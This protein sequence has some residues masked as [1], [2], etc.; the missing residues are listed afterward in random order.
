MR[1]TGTW[2]SLRL[3]CMTFSFANF[4]SY[5]SVVIVVFCDNVITLCFDNDKLLCKPLARLIRNSFSLNVVCCCSFCVRT[6][7]NS[8]FAVHADMDIDDDSRISSERISIL[9]LQNL[10]LQMNHIDLIDMNF[11]FPQQENNHTLPALLKFEQQKNTIR[12]WHFVQKHTKRVYCLH[13]I[14]FTAENFIRMCQQLFD[15]MNHTHH[16]AG[17]PVGINKRNDDRTTHAFLCVAKINS[18]FNLMSS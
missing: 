5:F 13:P 7:Y 6:S 14:Q 4:A 8:C 2:D 3:L 12:K 16:S 11:F 10:L 15:G 9:L 1:W 18:L 17:R